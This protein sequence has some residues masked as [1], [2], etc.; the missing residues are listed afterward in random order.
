MWFA[1]Q[2]WN[3][4]ATMSSADS[5]DP[6][7]SIEVSSGTIPATNIEGLERDVRVLVLNQLAEIKANPQHAGAQA[8][9]GLI[10]EGNRIWPQ[11][12]EAFRAAMAL[13][14]NNFHWKYHYAVATSEAG[15][16]ETAASLFEALVKADPSFAPAQHRWGQA[17]LENG[18][19]ERAASAFEQ[20][21]I[22]A[23]QAAEGYVGLADVELRKGQ[24][25]SAIAALEQAL[26]RD[27]TYKVVHFLLGTALKRQGRTEEAQK[28]LQKGQQ[29]RLRFLTDELTRRSERYD[30]TIRARYQRA[31]QE[32]TAGQTP[33]AIA[34]LEDLLSSDPKHTS[35]LNLLAGAYMQANRAADALRILQRAQAADDGKYSTYINLASWH[36]NSGQLEQALVYAQGAIERANWVA[37]SHYLRLEI[38][39]RLKRY[40]QFQTALREARQLSDHD[41][42]LQ[43]LEARWKNEKTK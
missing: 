7:S 5:T 32:L 6:K 2:F 25:E 38:L 9:L 30:V 10:Y 23:P 22:H 42:R 16:L 12:R 37:S 18:D 41:E 20:V 27:N 36:L 4:R 28:W 34:T 24:I 1:A 43:Q 29:G 13:E 15:D 26:Q 40:D 3:G 33:A 8:E 39:L 21:V 17:C 14:P 11:A 19:Y 31:L 35:S